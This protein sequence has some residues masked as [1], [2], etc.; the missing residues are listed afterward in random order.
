MS[1]ETSTSDE[2]SPSRTESSDAS[3]TTQL[4]RIDESAQVSASAT[5]PE[6]DASPAP[7]RGLAFTSRRVFAGA[8]LAFL[9]LVGWSAGA[10]LTKPGTDSVAARLSGWARDHELG[11][12][13]NGLEKVQYNLHKPKKGG[14][15]EGGI[16]LNDKPTPTPSITPPDLTPAPSRIASQ[17]GPWLH[18]EGMWQTLVSTPD[19]TP[20]LRSAFVRPDAEHT[21]Y[22]TSV[23]WMDQRKVRLE[24]HPGTS[25]PGGTWKG[26]NVLT[27]AQFPGLVAAFNSGFKLEGARGGYYSEGREVRA[28]RTGAASFVI[29]RD[30]HAQIGAWNQQVRM[31]AD[32][33]SVRQN[34]DL[35]VDRGQLAP[36]VDENNT[37]TWGFTLGN[38]SYVWRSG[39]GVT[40]TGALVYAAGN[41]MSVRTIGQVLKAAGAIRAME[42]DINPD[43]TTYY[44]FEHPAGG[45]V[46]PHKLAQDMQKPADRYLHVSSRDFFSV[47]L[48]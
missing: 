2:A 31:S 33:V 37:P 16:Q 43:W 40:R 47:H 25:E 6:V 5:E 10:Y 20:V 18:N 14:E 13:V 26:T 48:R 12:V 15:P 44:W 11:F 3:A 46:V 38:K 24:L 28:L 22:L 42:L 1:A 29:Y 35:L 19:G 4:P 32:V 21:S 45:G 34:L 39:V 8:V 36:T 41:A 9:G 7:R 23:A 30:G 27:P 17:A